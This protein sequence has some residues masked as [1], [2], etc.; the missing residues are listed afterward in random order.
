M[1]LFN[2]DYSY[3][4]PIID[5]LYKPVLKTYLASDCIKRAGQVGGDVSVVSLRRRNVN[6]KPNPLGPS[7]PFELLCTRP[8]PCKSDRPKL[9]NIIQQFN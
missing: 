4:S 2:V 1:V 8:S 9:L 3:Q 7:G 5:I 6:S